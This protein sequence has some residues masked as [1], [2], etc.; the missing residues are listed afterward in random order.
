MNNLHMPGHVALTDYNQ[1][2]QELLDPASRFSRNTMGANVIL[3]RL[4]DWLRFQQD[5]ADPY[6]HLERTASEFLDALTSLRP[7]GGAARGDGCHNAPGEEVRGV[8]AEDY[9]KLEDVIRIG[10]KAVSNLYFVG[11]QVS[12]FIPWRIITTRGVTK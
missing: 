1:I 12:D 6:E 2:F 9:R 5:V 4:E 7:Y 11:T 8:S 3:V 10:L